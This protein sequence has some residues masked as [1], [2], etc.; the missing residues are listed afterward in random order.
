MK[1]LENIKD[2]INLTKIDLLCIGLLLLPLNLTLAGIFFIFLLLS[3][4]YKKKTYDLLFKLE[5]TNLLI[6]SFLFISFIQ[7][8]IAIDPLLH[9]AGLFSHY[10]VYI[11]LFLSFNKIIKNTDEIKKIIKFICYS[12]FILSIIGFLAYFYIISTVKFFEYEIYGAKEYLFNFEIYNQQ[13]KAS[14]F[15]MNPNIM[16]IYL[17]ITFFTTIL[18]KNLNIINKN[19]F[20]LISISQ[21]LAIILTKSRGGI[22]VFLLGLIFLFFKEKKLD[23]NILFFIPIFILIFYIYWQTYEVLILSLFDIN[24]NSNKL[25]LETWNICLKIIESFPNGIGI[26]NYEKIY[27][28]YI[29]YNQQY[30]PHAHNWILHTTIESGIFASLI[31]FYTY[32]YQI[33]LLFKKKSY[34]TRQYVIF[35][36]ILILFFLFNLTD[37]VLTDTRICILLILII[38]FAFNKKIVST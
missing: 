21:A 30:I 8:S 28:S 19:P 34:F 31:F 4:I 12:G 37:Y 33:Y 25:R 23:K 17:I 2:K 38:F 3:E 13:Q 14:S 27:P 11:L 18:S 29:K 16:A 22:L 6:F 9:I 5:K 7:I 35:N 26:L 32:F 1:F 24:F 10:I 36:L 15:N 20:Y